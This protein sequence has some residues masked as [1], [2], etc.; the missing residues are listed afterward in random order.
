MMTVLIRMCR[1]SASIDTLR[2][3]LSEMALAVMRSKMWVLS[4]AP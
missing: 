4:A 3:S 2:R 1:D